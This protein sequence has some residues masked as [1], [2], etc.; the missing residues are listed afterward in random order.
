M[1]VP[2]IGLVGMGGF[3]RTHKQ[4]IQAVEEAGIGHQI[5]Q[6]AI[7]SDQALFAD[8]L[9]ELKGRGVRIFSACARC[10]LG[11]ETKSTWFVSPRVFRC[12]ALWQLPRSKPIVMCW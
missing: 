11:A 3:A 6:V 7:P 4:Y 2:T 12:I 9:A 8:E 5:A 1:N 10:W